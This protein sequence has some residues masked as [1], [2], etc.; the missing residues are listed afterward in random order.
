MILLYMPR[1]GEDNDDEVKITFENLDSNTEDNEDAQDNSEI[2]P[3]EPL[4]VIREQI[5]NVI[6]NPLPEEEKDEEVQKDDEEELE[7]QIKVLASMSQQLKKQTILMQKMDENI[8]VLHSR[9][10]SMTD[11]LQAIGFIKSEL[12][13]SRS[14]IDRKLNKKGR[15]VN[16]TKNIGKKK[17]TSPINKVQKIHRKYKRKN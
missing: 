10:N 6:P 15:L 8:E 2:Y 12:D 11:Q 16:R 14:R 4:R 3:T 7:R 9:M 1:S 13:S 5:V 17:S